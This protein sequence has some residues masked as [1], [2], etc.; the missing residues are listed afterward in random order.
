[1]APPVTVNLSASDVQTQNGSGRLNRPDTGDTITY[2]FGRPIN[3]GTVQLGWDGTKPASC[4]SPAPPG[5]VSVGVIADDKFEPNGHDMIKIFK[6][7][8]RTATDPL[9]QQLT[10][11]GT[12]DSGSDTY[13]GATGSF[14]QSP[15]E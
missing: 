15:M 4:A 7:P 11:L 10:S 13:V 2:S 5:C 8:S 9:N 6:D 1:E 14:L 3:P 12:V